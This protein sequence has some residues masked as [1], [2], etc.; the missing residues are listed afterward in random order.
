MLNVDVQKRDKIHTMCKADN[1][2]TATPLHE[3]ENSI[4]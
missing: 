2:Q 3:E 4:T 1:I